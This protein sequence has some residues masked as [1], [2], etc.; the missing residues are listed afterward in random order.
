MADELTEMSSRLDYYHPEMVART[1]AAQAEFE[2]K[3]KGGAQ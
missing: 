1:L 3:R 2:A